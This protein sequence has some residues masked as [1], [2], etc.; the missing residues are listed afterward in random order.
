VVGTLGG[1]GGFL[2][3]LG[4]GYLEELTGR[5][6]SCFWGVGAVTIAS[7]FALSVVIKALK[8]EERLSL[9]GQMAE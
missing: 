7:L 3:P 9:A 6:E 5:P 8:R 2:L 1:L 4:F